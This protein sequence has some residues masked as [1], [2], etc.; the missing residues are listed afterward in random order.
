[1]ITLLRLT[2]QLEPDD[3]GKP[4]FTKVITGLRRAYPKDKMDELSTSWLFICALQC[5]RRRLYAR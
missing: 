5:V 2:R 4:D 3:E 1:M